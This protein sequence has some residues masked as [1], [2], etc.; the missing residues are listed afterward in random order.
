MRTHGPA[1]LAYATRLTGGPSAGAAVLEDALVR[2]FARG[3]PPES[4]DDARVAVR[5]AVRF[6][7]VRRE[8][9]APA[10][11]PPEATEAPEVTDASSLREALA[12]LSPRERALLA[13]RYGDGLAVPAIASSTALREHQVRDALA[14]AAAALGLDVSDTVEGGVVDTTTVAVGDAP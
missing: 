14:N 6:V 13:I 1:L 9:P 2:T 8:R 4:G 7:A 10:T 3:R 12:G 11:P 5:D